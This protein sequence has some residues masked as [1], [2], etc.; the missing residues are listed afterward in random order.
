MQGNRF[1]GVLDDKGAIGDLGLQNSPG[2]FEEQESVVV[3]GGASVQVQRGALGGVLVDQV[4]GLG[5]A[6]RDAVE[7]HIEIDGVGTGHEA[8]IGNDLDASFAG[9]V[10]SGAS[11]SSVLRADDQDFDALGQQRFDV[12]FFFG[13]IALAEHDL[14]AETSGFESISETG[15]V[16]DP[17][18]FVLG[19]K[20]DTD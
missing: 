3:R 12:G 4:L 15:F 6:N 19:R 1:A 16:L 8:V 13:G 9:F 7:G 20:N 17:A 10:N 11:S 18:G 2:A 14:S 5:L